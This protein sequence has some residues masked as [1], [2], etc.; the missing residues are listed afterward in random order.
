MRHCL[1]IH[2]SNFF[3]VSL[4]FFLCYCSRLDIMAMNYFC[5][6]VISFVSK[7]H[8]TSIENCHN[9]KNVFKSRL[10][11]RKKKYINCCCDCVLITRDIPQPGFFFH[12]HGIWC[13]CDYANKIVQFNFC[14]YF[15]TRFC[16]QVQKEIQTNRQW[17]WAR[18]DHL[19]VHSIGSMYIVYTLTFDAVTIKI[20]HH[21][22]SNRQG[23]AWLV[24]CFLTFGFQKAICTV[25]IWSECV[26]LPE[27]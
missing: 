20:I 19:T 4:S 3:C 1:V 2:S 26:S 25:D 5:A 7:S 8:K 10:R 27:K 24:A 22:M 14:T 16:G 21:V 11:K 13:G 18:D 6:L 23:V 12:S 9:Q 17:V 15:C